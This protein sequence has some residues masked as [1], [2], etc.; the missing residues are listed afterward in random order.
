MRVLSLLV[1]TIFLCAVSASADPLDLSKAKEIALERNPQLKAAEA[2]IG[3]AQAGVKEARSRFLP[4]VDLREMYQRSD[5][6][7]YVFSSKL[8][9][10]YF[11]AQDFEL[12]R[13]NYPSPRTDLVTE[14]SVTQPIFNRGQEIVGYRKARLQEKMAYLLREG[15][16]QRVLYET[17]ASYLGLLLAQ[18]RV[19]VVAQA[20]ETA[21][22]NL[23]VVQSRVSVGAALRSDLLQAK[24]F[25]ASLEREY[26][27][28]KNM[29]EVARSRLNVVLGVPLE[30]RWQTK[31]VS[32]E[33]HSGL[34]SLDEWTEKALKRRPDLLL[35]ELKLALANEEVRGA[36]L[37]FWPAVNLRGVY[38]YHSNGIGGVSGDAFTVW[39]QLDFNLFKGFGDKARLA[40]ARAQE[41][42]QA[43]ELRHYKQRVKHEVE[44]AYL[45]LLTAR[46]QVFVTE[47]A[48]AQAEEGLRLVE[49]RYREGLTIIV[50]LLDAQTALKKA[51]L[52]Y[53][54]ALYNF[55]LALTELLFRTG[56]LGED[57]K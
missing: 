29:V 20:V 33:L 19:E 14:L 45:N 13:L 32:I 34:G 26:L 47:A 46:K 16:K 48:V 4:R 55:R 12:D 56:S 7:V 23:K 38:E 44:Q 49:K 8:A 10:Q 17:E 43:E 1:F 39:A 24:V 25:L 6:P 30:T 3:A 53:L 36:K 28:A 57:K 2:R 50:E 42:A 51:R 18:K 22:A 54:D 41:T 11:R 9:Q 21:K 27:A 15:V 5:S 40:R 37:N 52:Q 31:E 35:E